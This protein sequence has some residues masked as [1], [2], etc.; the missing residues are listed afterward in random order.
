M[1]QDRFKQAIA[2]IDSANAQDPHGVEMNGQK[3]PLE[4]LHA[5]RRTAWVRRLAGDQAS[6]ALLLAARAQHIRRWEIPRE[7]YLHDRIEQALTV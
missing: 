7:T 6:E 2:K 5:Q 1:D 4:I 3:Y